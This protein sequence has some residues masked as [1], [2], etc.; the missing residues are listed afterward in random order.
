MKFSPYITEPARHT[1]IVDSFDVMVCGA[2]PA[3]VCAALAAAR[4]G[5]RTALL[6][7][8]G[9]LGGV[10]TSGL[11]SYVLDADKQEGLLPEIVSRLKEREAHRPRIL[12][13]FTFDPEQMKLVLEEL[14]AASGVHVRLHTRVVAAQVDH[15]RR[16]REVVTES[17]TGR[18]A[19]R[20]SV[21]ID[22]TGD[23]DLAA[24]AG[25][26]YDYGNEPDGKGQPMSLLALVS[27]ID[28]TAAKRFYDGRAAERRK[29]LYQEIMEA[30]VEPSYSSPGLFHIREDLFAFMA[31][32]HY[33]S[34]PD[35]AQGLTEATING[36]REIDRIVR[37][38]RR[39]EKMEWKNLRVIATAEQIGI[40]EGRRIHG[41]ETVTANDLIEGRAR[42]NSVCQA[43][44]GMDVHSPNPAVA[45]DFDF[46]KR[47]P[48]KPYDIPYGALV[49]RDIRG[50]MM[51]GRCISGDFLAH[52]SY[53]VTG[54][55][56]VLGE[57]AGRAA[58][59]C[60]AEGLLPHELH[61]PALC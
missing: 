25:C 22:C 58:A 11:L 3:G 59:K 23:G 24:Y 10:W 9:A 46:S 49:A 53:R 5:A 20:A 15:D 52:S 37:A 35:D 4:G 36:R 39:T 6:E 32:H 41:M 7:V 12:H 33:G 40:R 8:H 19:W 54:N 51:A 47:K 13:D 2:G 21:F 55:A 29:H 31:H 14:C 16:L 43:T 44:F 38:L 1:P 27:G 50:L 56:V 60:V 57:S 45:K 17:K 42:A 61:L 18:E 26:G 30:G 28:V 34:R 48:V